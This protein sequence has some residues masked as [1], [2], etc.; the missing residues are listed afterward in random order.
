MWSLAAH[1]RTL[2]VSQDK[3]M[4]VEVVITTN[5]DEVDPVTHSFP[6]SCLLHLNNN[7]DV[8]P[9]KEVTATELTTNQMNLIPLSKDTDRTIRLECLHAGVNL[10]DH[11]KK[12][13]THMEAYRPFRR[14]VHLYSES[15]R[16][17]WRC[18]LSTTQ[19][20]LTRPSHQQQHQPAG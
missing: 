12:Q 11:P 18:A 14:E 9:S 6:R 4:E 8:G 1:T 10:S 17:E 2:T 13:P 15:P 19:H 5:D 3:L 7:V 16:G 20:W